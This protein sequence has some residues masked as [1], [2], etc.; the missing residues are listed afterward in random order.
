[1]K[2][3]DY[4]LVI[5]SEDYP[6][7]LYRNKYC[8]EH[9]FVYWKTYGIIPKEDEIIHH[10]DGN[11][12]NNNPDN[13]ELMKNKDH[14]NLHHKIGRQLVE[15]QCPMCGKIFVKE[16]NKTHLVKTNNQHTFCSRSCS[17]KFSNGVKLEYSNIILREFIDDPEKYGLKR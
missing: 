1:M 14:I 6:G 7:K 5:P 12:Q 13:L 2:N 11:K 16:K 8:S 4:N 3:G 15:L 9:V 10:K 17:A